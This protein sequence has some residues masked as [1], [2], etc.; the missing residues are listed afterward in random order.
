VQPPVPEVEVADDADGAR[1]RRPHRERRADDAFDLAYVRAEELVDPLVAALGGE[2]E[3]ELAEGRRECVRVVD[4]EGR[5]LRVADLEPVAQRELGAV[6]LALEQAC[7][8]RALELDRLLLALDADLDALRLGSERTDDDAA[9]VLRVRP[10]QAV[11]I[12]Q[13][14]LDELVDRAQ[15]GRSFARRSGP[16]V[17]D[18]RAGKAR[19]T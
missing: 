3:V 2:M 9:A 12:R 4:D 5:A 1:G 8:V 14:P 10:E 11:R 7:G 15:S 18:G 13:P 6:E 17:S 16:V 19:A